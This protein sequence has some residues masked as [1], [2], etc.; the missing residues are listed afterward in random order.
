MNNLELQYLE[1]LANRQKIF[2]FDVLR[3]EKGTK[4]IK[5]KS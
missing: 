5:T 3:C 4:K 1:I 2:Q